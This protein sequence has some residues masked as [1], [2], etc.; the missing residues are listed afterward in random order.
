MP[1][2]K[3]QRDALTPE[4]SIKFLMEGN[5]RFTEKK[6]ADRDDR[7]DQAL[8]ATEGQFPHS[9]VIS[10]IDSRIH[11]KEYFD[12]ANGDIFVQTAAGATIREDSGSE[13]GSL[14]F[15]CISGIKTI[16]VVGHSDCGAVKG[17]INGVPKLHQELS[18]LVAKIPAN[19]D[20]EHSTR[21][22]TKES[23]A[24]ILTNP[25]VAKFVNEGRVAICDSYINLKTGIVEFNELIKEAPDQPAQQVFKPQADNSHRRTPRS[26]PRTEQGAQ[27]IA[28]RLRSS[29]GSKKNKLQHQGVGKYLSIVKHIYDNK[30]LDF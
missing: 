28:K 3:E 8:A 6:G 27:P 26:H 19:D 25:T 10:C 20:L 4:E 5:G 1:L 16:I 17:A 9:L 24:A 18:K 23:V 29:L 2:T 12:Q 11:P 30:Q 14:E 21:A 22:N 7:D 15:A 13:L